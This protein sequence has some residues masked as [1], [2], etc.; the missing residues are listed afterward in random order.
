MFEEWLMQATVHPRTL[1]GYNLH[2]SNYNSTKCSLLSSTHTTEP[3]LENS[4]SS[5]SLFHGYGSF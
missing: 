1:V 5:F 4:Y 3:R 2:K